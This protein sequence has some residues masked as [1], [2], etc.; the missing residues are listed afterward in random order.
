MAELQDDD[1]VSGFLQR[2]I[3]M[4]SIKFLAW[5]REYQSLHI[6]D[7]LEAGRLLTEEELWSLYIRN[8]QTQA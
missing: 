7:S 6:V 1:E 4:K 5:T 3:K 8:E 2:V